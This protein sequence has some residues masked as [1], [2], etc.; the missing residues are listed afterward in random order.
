MKYQNNRN[1]PVSKKE[2]GFFYAIRKGEGKF[3]ARRDNKSPE[4]G[5]ADLSAPV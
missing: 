1:E 5:P 4:D 3:E 2:T